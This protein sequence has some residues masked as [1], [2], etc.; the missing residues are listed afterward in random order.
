MRIAV[1][2]DER[3]ELGKFENIIAEIHGNYQVDN[4]LSAGDLLRA[5]NGGIKYE[6][7]FLDIY[8][9]DRNGIDLAKEIQ[10]VSPDTSI[11]FT[12]VS[13]EH[14]VEA[15]SVRALHYL[16]K[17]LSLESVTEVFS[18]LGT[19]K[20]LRHTLTLCIERNM[21]VLFQ[22]EIISV[23][24]HLHSTLINTVNNTLFSVWKPYKEI[25]ELLDKNFLNIKKGVTV[26][27]HYIRKMTAQKCFMKDGRE[28]LLRR[29]IAK[30]LRDKYFSFVKNEL[31]KV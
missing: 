15:F 6:L 29:E 13:T 23:I 28:F 14:A 20:E 12:T 7:I 18:R 9:K 1:C 22:D 17:P 2:D 5:V 21:T 4:F 27:M 16:V 30:E 8:L 31:E 26:N 11:V 10:A 3:E 19:K 25:E 24:A